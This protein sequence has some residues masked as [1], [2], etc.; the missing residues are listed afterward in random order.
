MI[1]GRTYNHRVSYHKAK[2]SYNSV[3]A[4]IAIACHRTNKAATRMDCLTTLQLTKMP[5]AIYYQSAVD[6]KWPHDQPPEAL[7]TAHCTMSLALNHPSC[8]QLL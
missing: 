3:K 2:Y 6:G 5:T 7:H 1:T 4:G 8:S